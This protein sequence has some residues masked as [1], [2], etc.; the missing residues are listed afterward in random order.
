[1]EHENINW[2]GKTNKDL[3]V[4]FSTDTK[5]GLSSKNYELAKEKYGENIIDPQLS[6]E[7]NF[8]GMEKKVFNYRAILTRSVGMFGVVYILSVIIM[9]LIGFDIKLFFI[10]GYMFL[11]ISALVLFVLS[12]INY[13]DLYKK[14]RPKISVKRNGM[15]LRVSVESIVPGDLVVLSKGDIVPAD[16]KIITSDNLSCRHKLKAENIYE[17]IRQNKT[18]SPDKR[19]YIPG[20]E[21]DILYASDIIESGRAVAVI[22]ATGQNTLIEKEHTGSAAR[23]VQA[24]KGSGDNGGRGNGNKKETST[25]QENAA[26][27]SKTLF[28]LAAA[29][30]VPAVFFGILAGRDLILVILTCLTA[31]AAAF[32]EQL[33]IIVDFALTSGMKKSAKSGVAAKKTATI[34]MLN[35]MDMLIAKKTELCA[36]DNLRLEKIYFT[37]KELDVSYENR[38]DLRYVLLN[39]MA[40]CDSENSAVAKAVFKAAEDLEINYREIKKLVETDYAGGIRS[41][42]VI[43]RRVMLACFGEAENIIEKCAYQI[44]GDEIFTPADIRELEKKL[45]VLYDKYDL[46][47]AVAL[48]ELSNQAGNLNT[49]PSDLDFYAFMV[50]SELSVQKSPTVRQDIA[51]LKRLGITPVML[52]ESS[53]IYT[54]KTAVNFGVTNE[55]ENYSDAHIS[56]ANINNINSDLRNLRV[57]TR[58]SE[59]NGIALMRA[60]RS[61]GIYAAITADN[62]SVGEAEILNESYISFCTD[63]A[64]DEVLKNK[65]SVN[66]KNM[67]LKLILKAVRNANL[68]YKN[69]QRVMIFCTGIFI[70]Q[71]LLIFT[72]TVFNGAYILNPAQILWSSAGTGFFCAVAIAANSSGFRKIKVRGTA[73]DDMQYFQI[74]RTRGLLTGLFVF[75]ATALTFFIY[76][77]FESHIS[78]YIGSRESINAQTAAFVAYTAACFISAARYV[79]IKNKIFIAA[80]VLNIVL[81]AFAIANA[82]ARAYLGFGVLF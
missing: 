63:N 20:L 24:G 82:P 13:Y 26:K 3:E 62:M 74:I 66:I 80:L 19:I 72:A 75:L 58:L 70:A 42:A 30:S 16:A 67:S 32:S 21:S 44:D 48:K 53:G 47:M 40:V 35:K 71:Y 65:S 37:D 9:E 73:A 69:A 23:R 55:R 78:E 18:H 49:A 22:F 27:V 61:Q 54:Y 1:M 76:F 6:Q 25:I 5:K 77:S 7:R 15:E 64:E 4:F 39:V 60:L 38:S 31:S 29:F 8:F 43:S 14:S 51:D 50:F 2:S 52:A 34:D 36:H 81:T 46:V 17:T 11:I 57:V 28:L 10:L 68:I 12:E 41:A 59:T 56:D 79:N 45:L 33:T